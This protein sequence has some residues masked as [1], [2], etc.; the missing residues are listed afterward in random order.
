M[1][2]KNVVKNPAITVGDFT[3]YNDFVCDPRQFQRNSVL[4][5]YPVNRETLTIG[6][7]CSIGCGAKFLFNSANHAPDLL[8]SDP[9]PIFYREWGIASRDVTSA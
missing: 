5:H 6:K 4:H 8:S 2:L 7:F 9:F 3:I 1:Y